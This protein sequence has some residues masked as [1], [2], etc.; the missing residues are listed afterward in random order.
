M[1]PC[2]LKLGSFV[3][4]VGSRL[5]ILFSVCSDAGEEQQTQRLLGKEGNVVTELLRTEFSIQ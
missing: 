5:F 1:I 2:K 4:G 3:E